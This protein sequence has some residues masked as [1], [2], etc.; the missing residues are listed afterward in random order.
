MTVKSNILKL[1][2]VNNELTV[3]EIVG[4]LDVSKQMVHLVL[5]KLLE[6]NTVQKFGRTPKTIYRII[7]K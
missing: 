3:K 5:T 4:K 6:E 2:L 1:F 7:N